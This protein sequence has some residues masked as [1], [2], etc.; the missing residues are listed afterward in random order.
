MSVFYK[1]K[2]ITFGNSIQNNRE[3]KLQNNSENY[4]NKQQNIK[5]IFKRIP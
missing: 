1:K 4:K 2:I 3:L 5:D